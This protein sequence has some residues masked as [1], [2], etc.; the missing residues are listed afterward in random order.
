MSDRTENALS[1]GRLLFYDAE[2]KVASIEKAKVHMTPKSSKYEDAAEVYT[3]A[4]QQYQL[5]KSFADAGSAYEKAAEC[6][7]H[8]KFSV[9]RVPMCYIHAA[10]AF[11]KQDVNLAF[12]P[13]KKGVLLL[14]EDG[15]FGQAAKY[16]KE[17]A[18]MYHST[19]D[20]E[21]TIKH[22]EIA[23][24][25][26]EMEGSTATGADCWLRVVPLYAESGQYDKAIEYL[27]K[28]CDG[29]IKGLA[30]Y[31]IKDH[32][33]KA[34]ILFLCIP[35]HVAAKKNLDKWLKKYGEV[36]SGTSEHSFLESIISCFANSDVD[37]YRTAVGEYM[38]FS[39]KADVVFKETY[40]KK[41]EDLIDGGGEETFV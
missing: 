19:E 39:T 35:D 1:K 17:L 16:E 5:A 15:K 25:Y 41:A 20:P 33:V 30:R 38:K 36:L 31:S 4:A 10:Q 22:Y 2:K 23:G 6:Y 28:I 12:E 8:S 40:L 29:T 27:E 13:M 21:N 37:G 18:E 3:K 24:D 11:A 34:G 9:N 26:F 32:C 7:G 14:A